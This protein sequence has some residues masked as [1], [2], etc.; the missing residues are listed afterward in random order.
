MSSEPIA[1]DAAGI[2]SDVFPSIS[3]RTW[4]RLDSSGRCP[5]GFRIGGRKVWRV[6]DLRRWAG[7]GF[8]DRQTFDARARVEVSP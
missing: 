3:L 8:P 2:V 1:L 4:R 7:V 6:E 5:R